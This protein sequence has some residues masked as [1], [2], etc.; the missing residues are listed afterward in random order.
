MDYLM[1]F[2][3]GL[4]IAYGIYEIVAFKMK[5]TPY[6]VNKA[7]RSYSRLI[8]REK[9]HGANVAV[10]T[11]AIK[12]APFIKINQ[13]RKE[14]LSVEL[15]AIGKDVTPEMFKAMS[16]AKAMQILVCMIPCMIIWPVSSIAAL[17]AAYTALEK[18]ENLLR[19][20]LRNRKEAIERE[21]PRFSCTITQELK[22]TRDVLSILDNYKKNAGPVMK[23]ELEIT[24]ADMRTGN[25][26][27]ALQRFQTRISSP[28]LSDIVRG[29]LSTLRGDDNRTYF[30]ML[31]HDLDEMEIQRL[32]G[33][34]AKQPEK[35]RK[36][37][38]MLL[39][40]CIGMY[41]T[42][43]GVYVLQNTKGIG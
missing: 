4:L 11:L 17:I 41:L 15:K 33:I 42:I 34:A 16:I 28:A 40:C 2:L 27:A 9:E 7:A 35:L 30:E 26:E 22:V 5:L 24:V 31:S 18:D 14:Q 38:F 6:R 13:Y 29:L 19:K 43:L 21:L 25:Y 37:S 39:V 10:Q 36:Y 3:T 20:N 23:T 8:S 12:I 1:K 32:K